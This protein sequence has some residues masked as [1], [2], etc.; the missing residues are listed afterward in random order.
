[1]FIP[2]SKSNLSMLVLFVIAILLFYWV[3]SSRIYVKEKYFEE[4]LAAAELMKLAETTIRDFRLQQGIYIDE[5]NDPE[6]TTLIGEKQTLITTDRGSL[7]AKLT[8]LNPNLAA[9]VVEMF[10]SARLK[11][12]DTVA[13][14]CTGS[15]PGINL[16]VLSAA[17]IL[18][19]KLVIIC[20]VG[21]SMFGATDPEF[22]WL[23]MESLLIEK[24]VFSYK[25]V[26]ASIGGGRDLGRG[27]NKIGRD[28]IIEAIERNNILLI[29]EDSIEESI[30]K[31]FGIFNQKGDNDIKLYVNI[32]G[33][34]SSL[35]N[36]INGRLVSPGLHK[37][38]NIKNIPMK[39]TMFL[40]ADEGIPVIHLLDIDEIAEMYG[41]PIAPDPLPEP[42]TGKMYLDERYNTTFAVISLII[43]IILLIIVILFD[44][45][46][47]KIKEE[48]FKD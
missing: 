22:T 25:T 12:G 42:G 28:L 9:V 4:K 20:S 8:S 27:L 30:K 17:Q 35:G 18:D 6:K 10:K 21:A 24:R 15:F 16:A 39:G 23:D 29:K 5:V 13:L 1:M 45:H 19:L 48:V 38:L 44:H 2:S 14:N 26:A 37:I 34:L 41:L 31:K 33:G 43:M 46:Q 32:G 36:S 7:T 3:N 40:F 47:I 11:A